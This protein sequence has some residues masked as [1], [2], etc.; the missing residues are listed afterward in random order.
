M[1]VWDLTKRDVISRY[2]G[3]VLG[4]LWSFLTPLFLLVVY[5]FVFT[6][7]FKSRWGTELSSGSR[8]EYALLLFS[9]LA[10]YNF[11]AEVVMQAPTII[12]SNVNYVKKVVFPLQIFPIVKVGAALFHLLVSLIVLAIFTVYV[13]GGLPITALLFP[14]ALIPLVIMTIGLAWVFSA[15]GPYIRDIS[16]VL[17]PIVTGIL[18]VGP[19]L[20]PRKAMPDA[21]QPWLNLNPL[22]IPVEQLQN[23]MVWGVRPEV[24][25]LMGYT[26]VACCV[27]GLGYLVFQRVRAGFPDVL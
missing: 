6:V 14:L 18:F 27:A 8:F 13:R 26:L 4:V 23:V 20:Y 15:L 21:L 12:A 5:T 7:I 17:G 16:L 3:S 22:T 19:I 24:S 9:G 25:I 10:L 1:L 11:F 2:K